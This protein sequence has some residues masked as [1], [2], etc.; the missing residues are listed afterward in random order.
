MGSYDPV[1]YALAVDAFTHAGTADPSRISPTVCAQPF[2][3][4]VDQ[5]TFASDYAGYLNAIGQA[6]QNAPQ[7]PAEPPLACYVFASCQTTPAHHASP[8]HASHKRPARKRRRRHR[9][10]SRPPQRAAP[11]QGFTG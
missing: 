10:P 1:G 4:G 3:P 11:P 8:H 7:I 6:Q 5:S 2:Q 9:S